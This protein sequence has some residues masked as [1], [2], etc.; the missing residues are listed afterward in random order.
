MPRLHGKV[1][2]LPVHWVGQHGGVAAH[3]VTGSIDLRDPAISAL[4]NEVGEVLDSL[5]ASEQRLDGGM[6]LEMLHQVVRAAQRL[7]E[8]A[9]Q[10]ASSD[11]ERVLVRVD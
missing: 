2:A 7:V 1:R 6:A 9:Q 5:C 10:R 8:L 11:G 3:Q 4:G